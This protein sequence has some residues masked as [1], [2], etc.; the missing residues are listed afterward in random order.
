MNGWDR[1]ES[2]IKKCCHSNIK[3]HDNIF[4]LFKPAE[5]LPYGLF[6]RFLL[7]C[8]AI[9]RCW[10]IDVLIQI[11]VF[12]CSIGRTKQHFLNREG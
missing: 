6:P 2:L 9:G 3:S 8:L 5:F 11:G 7:L 12:Y 10:P 4:T 1:L